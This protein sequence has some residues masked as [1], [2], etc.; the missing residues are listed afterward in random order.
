[1]EGREKEPRK[2]LL[3]CIRRWWKMPTTFNEKNEAG[4]NPHHH[5]RDNNDHQRGS[6]DHEA[7]VTALKKL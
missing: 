7:V 6:Y 5:Q 1:M 2:G 3:K 4:E